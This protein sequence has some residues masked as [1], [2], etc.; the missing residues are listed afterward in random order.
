MTTVDL[1]T[2]PDRP[3]EL[4]DVRS[5]VEGVVAEGLASNADAAGGAA[6]RLGLPPLTFD[7]DGELVTFSSEPGRLG[8]SPAGRDA[9]V[10]ALDVPAFNDLINDVEAWLSL[11]APT[12]FL[13]P[14]WR[15]MAFRHS[16]LWAST[17]SRG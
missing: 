1:R 11:Q 10:V 7:I 12:Q 17:A 5:L 16:A 15:R 9:L 2:R 8:V 14:R 3:D 6:E 13:T 4:L